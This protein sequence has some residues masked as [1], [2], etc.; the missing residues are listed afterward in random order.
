[1]SIFNVRSSL[2]PRWPPSGQDP[3]PFWV[4]QDARRPSCL[5]KF[6]KDSPAMTPV[7]SFVLLRIWIPGV[8]RVGRRSLL[9]NRF[10]IRTAPVVQY[11]DS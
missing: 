4:I 8:W 1:M 10:Q 5:I 7:I 2:L 9:T 6:L 3:F 11:A